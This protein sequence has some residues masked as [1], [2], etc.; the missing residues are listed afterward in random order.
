MAKASGPIFRCFCCISTLH[1]K[2]KIGETKNIHTNTIHCC[3]LCEE[4]VQPAGR[5]RGH[6]WSLFSSVLV[7]SCSQSSVSLSGGPQPPLPYSQEPWVLNP[8]QRVTA[9]SRKDRV[10]AT[11]PASPPPAGRKTPGHSCPTP[12]PTRGPVTVLK[13]RA[14][15]QALPEPVHVVETPSSHVAKPL[16]STRVRDR[17]P[18]SSRQG[19]IENPHS[20]QT[21]RPWGSCRAKIDLFFNVSLF[22][23]IVFTYVFKI[24]HG[25]SHSC[26]V[27]ELKAFGR[28]V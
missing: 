10:T 17:E 3:Y 21:G 8:V 14:A 28:A 24:S 18:G 13:K 26:F 2:K 1:L 19:L 15:L 12:G 22:Y 6:T 25:L 11:R 16:P 20:H 27:M 4:M 5:R 9:P 23:F 7:G